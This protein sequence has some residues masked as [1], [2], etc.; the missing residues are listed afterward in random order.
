MRALEDESL[1]G[2]TAMLMI[3]KKFNISVSAG[4]IYYLLYV[5]ERKGFI[6]SIKGN[7]AKCYRLTKKGETIL[8]IITNIQN[9]NKPLNGTIF[10]YLSSF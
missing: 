7:S 9:R 3:R 5:L 6:I 8:S 4:T 10:P 2:Y 1:S